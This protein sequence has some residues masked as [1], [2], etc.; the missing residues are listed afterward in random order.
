MAKEEIPTVVGM[1]SELVALLLEKLGQPQL[2]ADQLAEI[3]KQTGLTTASA[4]QKALKPENQFHPGVSCYSYPEGDRDKPRPTLKCEMSWVGCSIQS[5]N[6][7]NMHWFELELLNQIDPGVY[8]VTK[9]DN[10]TTQ[11][12]ARGS[13]DVTGKLDRLDFTFPVRDG[14]RHNAAPMAVWLLEVLG[15]TYMEAMQ[16]YLQVQIDDARAKTQK[17]VAA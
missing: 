1:P 8:E 10:S 3:L 6:D 14:E 9:T 15:M 7:G 11:L 13:R 5:G 12:T 2:G 16:K 17:A 4:M